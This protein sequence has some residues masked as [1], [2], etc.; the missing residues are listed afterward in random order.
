VARIRRNLIRKAR[1]LRDRAHN[2]LVEVKERYGLLDPIQILPYRGYGTAGQLQ[3]RGRV[4]EDEGIT[5]GAVRSSGWQNLGNMYRRFASDEIAGARLRARF[6]GE[7]V[8]TET[9]GEGYF[10]LRFAPRAPLPADTDWH[11]IELELLD[12]RLPKQGPVRATGQVLVPPPDAAFGV[13]S[14]IDDTIIHTA[15][16]DLLMMARIVLLNSA[17]TR[18]PFPGVAAF[19]HA[20][21]AGG[22]G[23]GRNP[24]FYVSNS[25]WNLYDLLD[26]FLVVHGLPAGPLVLQDWG[27]AAAQLSGTTLPK[28]KLARISLL[29]ALYPDLPF[30][31]IGDSGEHDPEIYRQVAR[32]HPGQIR[33]I[34]IRHAGSDRRAREVA[35]I[36]A[37][38]E[39]VGVPLLVARDTVTLAWHAAA[40]GLIAP[41]SLPTISGDAEHD[42]AKPLR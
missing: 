27:R 12:P 37:E 30:V 13:I 4:L 39:G 36:A 34:Y 2:E 9:D 38:L 40:L 35:D 41:H 31:L 25:P 21:R 8:E 23:G 29:L 14:D 22:D 10:A 11:A 26:E 24:I 1:M 6:G 3:L 17:Q 33:A 5:R 42:R 18:A 7:T 16:T 20:L 15:V 32:Q 28:R 19:Y